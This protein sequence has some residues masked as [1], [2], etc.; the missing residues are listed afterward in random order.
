M[1]SLRIIQI[2]PGSGGTFYCQNCL[3][4]E[5]LVQALRGLGHEVI[6]V[7]MY[8]PHF[9]G[10]F[11]L[12]PD[13]PV[14]FGAISTYLRE[15]SAFFRKVPTWIQRML[16]ASFLL[17]WAGRK[18]GSTSAEGMEDMTLSMLRNPE[19][20]HGEE[21]A[22]L[23]AWLKESGKP[24][25]VHLSNALLMGL[26]E[27]IRRA[28]NIPVVCSLQDEN[29]WVDA[30]EPGAAQTIWRVMS[31][32]AAHVAAFVSVS[33]AYAAQMQDRMDLHQDKIH[34]V[35]V[36]L[37]FP[38]CPPAPLPFDPPVIGFLSKLSPALGLD[39]LVDAFIAIKRS[40]LPEVQLRAFGGVIGS[41][42]VFVADLERRIAREGFERDAAQFI[43]LYDP[44]AK[45]K[46]LSELTVLSV[47]IPQG[48]A[49]GLFQIEAMGFGIPV[50]QPD[51]GAFPEVIEA[52]GGGVIYDALQPDGLRN[53]LVSLLRDPD[54]ARRLGRLGHRSVREKFGVDQAARRT[55]DVYAR[56]LN[57]TNAE[58]HA[59]I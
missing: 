20:H 39:L 31:D 43:P 23:I 58:H 37:T 32:K 50:V 21:L 26:A 28:L 36:G 42:K 6:M 52:T 56:C 25:V 10:D 1:K 24:D 45:Q 9:Q 12:R 40:D 2:V 48:E 17:Q 7:P 3:R 29:T 14:F 57:Q 33:R 13:A 49:F 16:D 19:R 18:S 44:A 51:A 30:M 47:P 5:A 35:P 46:F 27:P 54:R 8:L 59:S 53:T 38:D 15:K 41:D 55:L 4:D 34:V 11:G 22:Q